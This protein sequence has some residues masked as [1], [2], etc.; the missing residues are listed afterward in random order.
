M[1]NKPGEGISEAERNKIEETED[2][3]IIKIS[4]S[5]RSKSRTEKLSKQPKTRQIW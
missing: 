2:I 3:Q 1:N 4:K 5:K